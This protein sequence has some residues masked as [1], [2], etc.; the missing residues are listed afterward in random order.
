[1]TLKEQRLNSGLTQAEC[2][3]LLQISR[4]TYQSYESD[5]KKHGSMMYGYLLDKL[6]ELTRIDEERGILSLEKIRGICARIFSE[7][8]IEYCYL[9]GSYAKGEAGPSSDVDLLVATP[10]KGMAFFELAEMLRDGLQKRVDVLGLEQLNDN[11]ELFNE[12]LKHGVK[13][14]G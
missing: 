6:T 1:M 10:L 12:I 8:D 5:E 13:I 3:A 9:F 2:A 7:L 11:P 4:R 14:Y